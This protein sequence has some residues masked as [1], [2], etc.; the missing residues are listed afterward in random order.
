MILGEKPSV[1]SPVRNQSFSLLYESN[2]VGGD[3][4]ITQEGKSGLPLQRISCADFNTGLE[5][6]K[7]GFD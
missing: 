1:L 2:V 3:T 5:V 4:Q 6:C 7:L